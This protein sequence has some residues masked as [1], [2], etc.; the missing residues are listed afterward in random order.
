MIEQILFVPVL[1]FSVVVH[2]CAHGIAANRAGDPTAKLMGRITLNPIPHIDIFGSIIIPVL[3]LVT[4]SPFL[5]GWAKPVPVNPSYFRDYRRDEIKV[6]LAGPASNI[7]LS[8][9]FLGL[10]IIVIWIS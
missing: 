4:H 2:E 6:S 9:L 8:F 1:I 7:L 3:L 10:T 5:F